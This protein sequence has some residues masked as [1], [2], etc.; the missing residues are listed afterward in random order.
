[1]K[2]VI[3]QHPLKTTVVVAGLGL[4]HDELAAAYIAQG[5]VPTS[6]GFLRCLERNR[7]ETFGES[8]SLKLVSHADDARLIQAY[9]LATLRMVQ[10]TT[11]SPAQAGADTGTA[12]SGT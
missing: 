2:Y 12:T 8:T 4:N 5:Y 11:N 6:A 9:S 10:P 7:F 1:M 3:L